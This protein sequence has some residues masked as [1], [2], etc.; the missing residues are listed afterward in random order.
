LG[1]WEVYADENEHEKALAAVAEVPVGSPW[2]RRA[3]FLTGVSQI[4][5]VKYDEAFNTFKLL[6]DAQ[7]TPAV[8]NNL[9]IVQLRRPSAAQGGRPT[10]YFNKAAEADHDDP[11]YAFNLGYAY[12]QIRDHQ[13]AAYWLREAV[14]RN[15]ADGDSHFVLGAALAASGNFVEAGRE[16]ELAKRLSASYEA[17]EKEKRPA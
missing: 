5:L 7:P 16:R 11:D 17:R 3:R 9:G 14:R 13:A 1:L 4:A 2:S 10:Y 6:A 15:P 8:L 12:W